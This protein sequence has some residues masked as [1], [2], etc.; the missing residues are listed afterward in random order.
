[1]KQVHS[2]LQDLGPQGGAPGT[3]L[4][5]PLESLRLDTVTDFKIYVLTKKE[6]EPVLYRAENLQFTQSA[7]KRLQEHEVTHVFIEG[8]DQDKYKEYVEQNLDKIVRDDSIETREKAEIV[9]SSATF[10]MQKLFDNPRAGKNIRRCEKL[11]LNTVEFVLRDDKAFENF[12]AV[13]SY[14]YYTYTHSVNVCIFSVAL[15]QDAGLCETSELRVLGTGALLHDIGKSLID[16]KIINKNGPLSSEE[17]KMIKKH[18]AHGVRI[19]RETGG[20]PEECYAVVSQHHERCDG[21]GYPA[22]LRG[23]E[24]HPYGRV[25]AIADVFDAM[26]TR[27]VYR[28]AVG[29]FTALQTMKSEMHD[30]LDQDMFLAFIRLLGR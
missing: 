14:D 28:D 11:A 5:I 22:G 16:K 12:L 1:M 15:A 20:V 13:T 7:K 21:S 17:W 23:D 30:K 19:L 24:I 27:R 10:L 6:K 8:N 2:R 26:T 29:T 18:P 9:Y 25:S 4:P 3:F